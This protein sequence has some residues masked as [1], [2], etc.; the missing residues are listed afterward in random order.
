M[1]RR[2]WLPD[3]IAGAAA[4]VTATELSTALIPT[5]RAQDA[6]RRTFP[7]IYLVSISDNQS[8]SH[9]GSV[10]FML[11]YSAAVISV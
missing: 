4:E 6:Q 1:K 2:G 5:P 7:I 8:Q 9:W 11:A 3:G 10:S